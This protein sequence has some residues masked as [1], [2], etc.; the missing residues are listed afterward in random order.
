MQ[1]S[2]NVLIKA[3]LLGEALAAH[4]RVKDYYAAQRAVRADETARKLLQDYQKQAAYIH[5]LEAE[6]KP[7]EVADKQK[8]REYE[9]QMAGNETLKN[10]MR[11]QADYVQLMTQ[12]NQ[13]MEAPLADL[14]LPEKSE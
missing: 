4:P 8:L 13:T 10:L 6:Q 3:K 7:V 9:T 2:E 1:D 12:V 11:A 5:Q 14:A